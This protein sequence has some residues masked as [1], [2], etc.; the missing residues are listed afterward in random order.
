M[1]IDR[2][3]MNMLSLHKHDLKLNSP[4]GE[5]KEAAQQFEAYMV[6]M[7]IREMR[8]TVPEGM[9]SSQSME[10]FMD[11]MDQAI[12]EQISQNGGLG[13]SSALEQAM[14]QRGTTL[15]EMM[16]DTSFDVQLDQ[17]MGTHEFSLPNLSDP[18]MLGLGLP[19]VKRPNSIKE[20]ALDLF[21]QIG[22]GA[23]EIAPGTKKTPKTVFPLEGRISSR[24]GHRVDPINGGHRHHDGLD[25]AAAKGTEIKAIRAGTVVHSAA[26]GT[27]GNLVVVD[28]G[29]GLKSYYAHCDTLKVSVGQ[30]VNPSTVIGTVGSTGRSTGP[31]LHLEIRHNGKA[32]DPLK[33]LK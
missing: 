13:F 25:I 16:G 30:K 1:S 27:F 14:S 8:K 22:L 24:F 29:A 28:H 6:Q 10:I 31:H 15:E 32:I 33:I 4:G 7:M 11:M 2:L 21:Q 17:A 19:D 20:S 23:K 5:E 3:G 9:F 12:A 26:K 18:D